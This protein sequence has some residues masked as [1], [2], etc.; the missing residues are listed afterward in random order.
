MAQPRIT[1]IING[2]TYSLCADNP[3]A[4]G[5]MP[6]E[7]R[8]H[9]LTLLEVVRRPEDLQPATA[10]VARATPQSLSSTPQN[11]APAAADAR[12]VVSQSTVTPSAPTRMGSGDIDALMARLAAEEQR[13]RKPGLTRAGIYKLTGGLLLL[14]F[15]LVVVL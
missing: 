2:T 6:A 1:V 12:V 4:I 15:L 8:L 7:D 5:N 13:G 9:L 14:V 11:P 3:Q 10:P